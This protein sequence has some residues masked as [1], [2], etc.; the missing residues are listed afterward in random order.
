MLL[1]IDAIKVFIIV[2]NLFL[3]ASR[4]H[5]WQRRENPL[6]ALKTAFK[7]K[8]RELK[9]IQENP[10]KDIFVANFRGKI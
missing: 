9:A 5:K 8:L 1:K 4:L 7:R 2:C 6:S 10:T 3:P